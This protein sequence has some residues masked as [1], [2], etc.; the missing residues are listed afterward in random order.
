MRYGLE[1]PEEVSD[2][3]GDH[4]SHGLAMAVQWSAGWSRRTRGGGYFGSV[5]NHFSDAS[6]K[7]SLPRRVQERKGASDPCAS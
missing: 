5:L 3:L 6:W 7:G 1:W 2:G 4:F